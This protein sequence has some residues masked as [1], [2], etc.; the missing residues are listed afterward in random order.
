VS[1]AEAERHRPGLHAWFAHNGVCR[2]FHGTCR[3]SLSRSRLKESR[4]CNFAHFGS[5]DREFVPVR[6]REGDSNRRSHE[7]IHG[8]GF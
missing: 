6:W 8:P 7:N 3:A 1:V 4:F 2:R 5:A